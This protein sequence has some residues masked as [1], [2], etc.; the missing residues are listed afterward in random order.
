MALIS[1]TTKQKINNNNNNTTELEN[2]I[3]LTET[4]EYYVWSNEEGE[5][6]MPN[7]GTTTFALENTDINTLS[8]LKSIYKMRI[9]RYFR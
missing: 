6:S 3:L 4:E 8:I 7:D 5:E 9:L 1:P 2:E